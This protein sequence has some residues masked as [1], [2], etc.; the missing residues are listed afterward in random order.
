M[1]ARAEVACFAR[2]GEQQVVAAAAAADAREAV[3]RVTAFEKALE[4]VPLDDAAPRPEARSSARWRLTH[5]HSGLARGL[6]GR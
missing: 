6:R 5:C 4:H 3:V 1:A 2:K